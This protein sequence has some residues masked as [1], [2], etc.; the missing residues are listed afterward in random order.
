LARQHPQLLLRLAVTPDA[1]IAHVAGHL[2]RAVQT[3][4]DDDVA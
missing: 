2:D 1:D 4:H 3:V